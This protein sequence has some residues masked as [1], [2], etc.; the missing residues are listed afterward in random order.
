MTENFD[1][2]N[3]DRILFRTLIIAMEGEMET[4]KDSDILA[5]WGLGGLF[6]QFKF[7]GEFRQWA[8]QWLSNLGTPP[9]D[10]DDAI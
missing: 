5:E 2:T 9:E 10:S 3:N 6:P 7:V 1:M 4:L 8:E